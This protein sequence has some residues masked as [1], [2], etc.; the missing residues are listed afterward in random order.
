MIT[1]EQTSK[2]LMERAKKRMAEPGYVW[3]IP[4]GFPA[5]DRKT[6]G[7]HRGQLAVLMAR[8][9]VGKSTFAGDVARNVAKWILYQ[10]AHGKR[11]EWWADKV[12]RIVSMEMTSHEW[13][14]RMVCAEA[15]I[16]GEAVRTGYLTEQQYQLY[17]R[18]AREIG[19]LPIEYLD[20]ASSMTQVISFLKE[21]NKCAFWIVDH[22]GIL[23]NVVE[24]N[25]S[26]LNGLTT[27]I[28]LFRTLARNH[29]PGLVLT[30][31]SRECEKRA[32]K[33]PMM[34]DIYGAGAIEAAAQVIISLY[35]DDLYTQVSE[36]ARTKPLP[37][38]VSLLKN[39]NGPIGHMNFV[40]VSQLPR[41]V[42]LAP[43]L[44]KSAA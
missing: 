21:G 31:M 27:T 5:L 14:E 44:E 13:Q 1:A 17:E 19:E 42:D 26:P 6:G 24:G 34:S 10:R 30:Q 33:R 16:D 40:F 23:P 4:W 35:R 9:S 11:R 38:E 37:A 28:G 25:N 32:D 36:D 39:R 7:I 22:L 12:V 43:P 18:A 3:G 20:E 15:G 29:A 8:P 41:W 2:D